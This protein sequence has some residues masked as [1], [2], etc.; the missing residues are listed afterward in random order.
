VSQSVEEV[1]KLTNEIYQKIAESAN[2]I[3]SVAQKM[4]D[5]NADNNRDIDYI[6]QLKTKSKDI[7]KIMEIINKISDQ[8][9]IISFNAALEASSAG[10]A[11]KRFAVVAAEIR[12]LTEDVIHSTADI[13]NL[14]SEIQSLSDKMVLA[15]EKTTKN[16]HHGLEA[17]DDSVENI[18]AIVGSIKRSNEATKQIVLAVQ[19]QQT[20][21]LQIQSG[22][23]E[24][25]E[26][27]RQNSEA[28]Q[29]ISESDTE[30]RS[31]TD[32]LTTIIAEFK[33]KEE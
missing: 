12:K 2:L 33:T 32:N 18:E 27:A 6:T 19:Q 8:T 25:S 14:V 7:S 31:V 13:D 11:G 5:I 17:G 29:A 24:L 26:G 23:K 16:I 21:A 1:S 28:I 15:S 3:D 20:A 9:K 30:Y 10:E 4:R 22:L